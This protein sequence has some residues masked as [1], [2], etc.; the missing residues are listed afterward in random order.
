[1][2]GIVFTTGTWSYKLVC[3][4]FCLGMCRRRKISSGKTRWTE[5]RRRLRVWPSCCR[6]PTRMHC[7]AD[8]SILIAAA[9]FCTW[10][11]VTHGDR[12]AKCYT[13]DTT[14]VVPPGLNLRLLRQVS[15]SAYLLSILVNIIKCRVHSYVVC[16]LSLVQKIGLILDILR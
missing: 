12:S 7:L 13:S 14:L 8:N 2:L 10:T 16:L 11:A 6:K 15:V 4:F 9:A 5:T 3:I 1:M